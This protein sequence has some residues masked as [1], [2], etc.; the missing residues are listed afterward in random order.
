MAEVQHVASGNGAPAGAPP[1]IAAHYVDLVSGLH[2]ISTGTAT[3][4]DWG[5]PIGVRTFYELTNA[6]QLD[7]PMS[8]GRIDIVES[9][10]GPGGQ[11][12]LVLPTVPLGGV[13]ELTVA[14]WLPSLSSQ[15][16]LKGAAGF[17]GVNF[18]GA[19]EVGATTVGDELHIPMAKQLV[20]LAHAFSGPTGRYLEVLPRF[21]G[22]GTGPV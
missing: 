4:A 9:S 12:V 1:S 15:I 20:L 14:A 13:L 5:H 2:Y 16:V 3:A 21:V 17:D 11:F 18:V 8:A 6:G 22:A 10:G 19:E 7:V